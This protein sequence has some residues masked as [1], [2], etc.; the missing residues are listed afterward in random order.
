MQEEI[1]KDVP[2]YEGYYQASNM[3]SVKSISRIVKGKMVTERS[4]NTSID[5]NGYYIVALYIESSKIIIRVHQLVAMAF[6]NHKRCGQVV[7]V[8]HINNIRTDNKLENL[9]L[10]TQ[11]ENTSKKKEGCSS[12]YIGVSWR[13][14]DSKWSVTIM[15]NAKI[16]YIGSYKSEFRAHLA[17]Q[18]ELLNHLNKTNF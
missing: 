6:L 8:D 16:K 12:K 5:S 18:N 2:E 13:K 15:I 4:V 3:G 14:R 17:Y 11:R 10:I 7:V 1:W 9:Q